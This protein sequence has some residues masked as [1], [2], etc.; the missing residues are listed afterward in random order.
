M[1]GNSV[2]HRRP[3]RIKA[4]GRRDERPTEAN[5]TWGHAIACGVRL[6][7]LARKLAFKSNF[8]DIPRKPGMSGEPGAKTAAKGVSSFCDQVRSEGK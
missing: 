2:R 5:S 3:P 4:V 8:R 7:R 6:E 1:G